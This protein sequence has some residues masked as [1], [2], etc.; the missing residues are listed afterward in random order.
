MKKRTILVI[1]LIVVALI[2]SSI[3]AFKYGVNYVTKRVI[4]KLVQTEEV[5]K[6]REQLEAL[7]EKELA[8]IESNVEARNEIDDEVK[9]I[10]SLGSGGEDTKEIP[11]LGG[12]G[13]KNK[14]SDSGTGLKVK[15]V[16]N[17]KKQS[18]LKNNVNIETSESAEYTGDFWS[19]PLVQ[20]VYSRFSS[21]EIAQA[22]SAVSGNATGAEK[23]AVKEM[24]LSRVSAAEINELQE[25][26]YKYNK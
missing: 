23:K 17:N 25:L 11:S 12:A 1:V 24:V 19:H 8:K 10:P 14:K 20:S 26:Y 13:G 22:M 2:V 4:D 16:Q 5:Q 6:Y 7:A 21:G 15:N 3:C 18:T 9:E